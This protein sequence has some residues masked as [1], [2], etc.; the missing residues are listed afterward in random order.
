MFISKIQSYSPVQ[1]KGEVGIP[2]T[3]IIFQRIRSQ[4]VAKKCHENEGLITLQI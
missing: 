4:V 2:G 1:D 3:W